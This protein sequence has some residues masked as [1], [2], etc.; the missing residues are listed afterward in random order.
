MFL[1][2]FNA[3]CTIMS[4]KVCTIKSNVSTDTYHIFGSRSVSLN[5]ASLNILVY[6][7]INLLYYDHWT[8]ESKY[9]YVFLIPFTCFEFFEFFIKTNPSVIKIG[10]KFLGKTF[11]SQSTNSIS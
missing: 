11:I 6:G 7:M 4:N 2:T 5:V 3:S 9:F 8:G 10:T 1:L